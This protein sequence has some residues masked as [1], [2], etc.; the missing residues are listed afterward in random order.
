MPLNNGR[1]LPSRQWLHG[2]DY[3]NFARRVYVRSQGLSGDIFNGRS[4]IGLQFVER[5]NSYNL[6]VR[7]MVFGT[8]RAHL[9]WQCRHRRAETEQMLPVMQTARRAI[10]WS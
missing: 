7:D 5:V 6:H 8:G 1:E 9:I 10:S 3:Y 2:P 4:V